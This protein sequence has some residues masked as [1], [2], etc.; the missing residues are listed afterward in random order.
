MKITRWVMLKRAATALLLGAAVSLPLTLSHAMTDAEVAEAVKAMR[1]M[2]QSE[3]QVQQF[4]ESVK[5]AQAAMARFQ[6]LEAG[7]STI[8]DIQRAAGLSEQEVSAAASI[9]GA[10]EQQQQ[11]QFALKLEQERAAFNARYADKPALT[12]R[13]DG[14]QLEM[15]LIDCSSHE[16]YHF[17]AQAPPRVHGETGPQLLAGRGWS[18]A[19]GAF[20]A[21][22]TLRI[23]D[24]AYDAELP[25]A[26]L[27]NSTLRYDGSVVSQGAEQ[28]TMHLRFQATCAQ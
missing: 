7:E 27:T 16:A 22:L 15:K 21:R 19:Q 1:A 9:A 11:Q 5:A 14:E 24:Q 2:G 20:V 18:V 4:L 26:D 3:A 23:D 6:G 8:E 25:S 28:Q 17:E 12:A 13:L 10:I